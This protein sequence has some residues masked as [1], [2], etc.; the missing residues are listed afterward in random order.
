VKERDW[1]E[2]VVFPLFSPLSVI[3]EGAADFGIEVAFPDD[4]RLAFERDV[5]YPIAGLDA[6]KAEAYDAIRR[7]RTELRYAEIEVAR[8]YLDGKIDAE[9]ATKYLCS[10]AL[11]PL[12][13]ARRLVTFFDRYRSYIISYNV[14][15]DLVK[16]Y[17]ENRGGTVG[18]PDKRWEEFRLLISYPRVPSE[19]R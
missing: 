16:R 18:H 5:L 9:K 15:Y 3:N 14:G 2:F 12:D 13:N 10:N 19:L 17:I 6:G 11:M 4:S 8:L 1:I 7:L